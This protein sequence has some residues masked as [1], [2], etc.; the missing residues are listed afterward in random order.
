VRNIYFAQNYPDE[1]SEQMLA[2]AGVNYVF[3]DGVFI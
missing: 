3:M 1:L 2:E